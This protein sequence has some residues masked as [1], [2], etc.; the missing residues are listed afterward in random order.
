MIIEIMTFIKSVW[1]PELFHVFYVL[2]CIKSSQQPHGEG[3]SNP[4][5]LVRMLRDRVI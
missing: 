1:V 5:L 4:I 2:L 3:T